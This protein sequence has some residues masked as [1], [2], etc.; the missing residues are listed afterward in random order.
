MLLNIE[1][2]ILNPNLSFLLNIFIF[3]FGLCFGSFLNVCIYRIPKKES[4]AINP[5]H[6]TA[7]G[8]KIRFYENIPVIS[9]LCLRGKCS[10][11][12][13]KISAIYPV[14]E[15]ITGIIILLLWQQAKNTAHPLSQILLYINLTFLFIPAFF[16]DIK[17]H[18]I[19]N[20]LTYPVILISFVLSFSFP[21]LMSVNSKYHALLL[22]V[23]GFL[24][25]GFLLGTFAFLGKL[26]CKKTVI[27]WGDVKYI[28]A[29]GAAFGIFSHAW[30]GI[31]IISAWIGAIFG[32]LLII[33]RRKKW[34]EA[35]PFGPFLVIGSYLW[36]FFGVNIE[37][38][39]FNLMQK[40][41]FY[42]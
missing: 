19:P 35:L 21:E 34:S 3:I 41:L 6:C 38:F 4:I 22:S 40:L 20:K 29:L 1:K 32:L 31:L 28:A 16:I 27:G 33:V 18:I 37:S 14:V 9:W 13:E 23:E 8:K 17:Y 2:I 42:I 36:I 11:C 12:R 7:C 5:S 25:A 10:N 15:I 30:P 24:A 39:Y 26:L